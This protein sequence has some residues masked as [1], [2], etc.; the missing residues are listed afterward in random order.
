MIFQRATSWKERGLQ[1][2]K[3]KRGQAPQVHILTNNKEDRG[4]VFT[5]DI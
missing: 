2:Q 5:F 4:Q 3:K 1:I